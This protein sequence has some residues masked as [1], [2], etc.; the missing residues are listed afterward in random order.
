MNIPQKAIFIPLPVTI[1]IFHLG[2][3]DLGQIFLRA[4]RYFLLASRP[5]GGYKMEKPF[6][7]KTTSSIVKKTSYPKHFPKIQRLILIYLARQNNLAQPSNSQFGQGSP[8]GAHVLINRK[9]GVLVPKTQ[10]KKENSFLL[11]FS[12]LGNFSVLIG[13][14]Q[15]ID[16]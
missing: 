4:S 2:L 7:I 5:G 9:P 13:S 3:C 10:H 15:L 6:K 16:H 1:G 14:Y 8:M 12:L 11:Y